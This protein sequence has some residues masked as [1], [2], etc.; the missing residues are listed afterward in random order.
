MSPGAE[1]LC[2]AAVLYLDGCL[3]GKAV[4]AL[5]LEARSEPA[6]AAEVQ[7]R[8]TDFARLAADDFTAMG[9][10]EPESCARLYVVMSAEA[11][12]VELESGGENEAVRQALKQFI[13]V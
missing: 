10:P 12:L 9:W 2:H 5:L 1:R 13:G 7:N 3:E 11:A 4:K 6:I 8:N